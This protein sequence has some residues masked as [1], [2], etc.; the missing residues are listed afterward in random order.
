MEGRLPVNDARWDELRRQVAGL[1]GDT[2]RHAAFMAIGGGLADRLARDRLIPEAQE[3]LVG[4]LI[5]QAAATAWG[6]HALE[7]EETLGV[8]V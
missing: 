7:V 8:G 6:M 4:V 5:A 2:E 1:E 3:R